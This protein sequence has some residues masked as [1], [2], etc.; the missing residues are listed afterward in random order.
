MIPVQIDGHHSFDV[1]P[2]FLV[3]RA[4]KYAVKSIPG[5]WEVIEY[6]K[7]SKSITNTTAI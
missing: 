6:D 2:E 7:I 5:T 1:K 3:A 4:K